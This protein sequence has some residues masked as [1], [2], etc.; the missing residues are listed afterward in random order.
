MDDRIKRISCAKWTS[1]RDPLHGQVTGQKLGTDVTILMSVGVGLKWHVH[2]NAKTSCCE[3]AARFTRWA[4]KRSRRMRATFC[5]VCAMCP[6]N[7]SIS[8]RGGWNPFT[9]I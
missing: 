4:N 5:W 6:I 3:R 8:A 7:S 1:G 2:L 9:C